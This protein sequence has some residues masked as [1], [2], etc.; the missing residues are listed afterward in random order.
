VSASRAATLRG[1]VL[2]YLLAGQGVSAVDRL[3]A[4]REM[5]RLAQLDVEPAA[6]AES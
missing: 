3:A 5:L 4:A 2:L 1:R 6:E